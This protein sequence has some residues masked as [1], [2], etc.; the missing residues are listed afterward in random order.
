MA[1]SLPLSVPALMSVIEAALPSGFEVAFGNT[2]G[3]YIAAQSVLVGKVTFSKDDPATIGPNYP[4]EE[5]YTIACTLFS[6]AGNNDELTRLSEVYTLYNE[7]KVAISQNPRLNNGTVDTVRYA[8]P[9]QK[10]Y[11]PSK[12]SNGMDVGR[13]DFVVY[14][15]ARVDSLD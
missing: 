3:I 11:S 9:K 13:L 1:N 8:W 12:D 10:G 15:E 2:V 6:S 14:C 5:H 7:I 4:H